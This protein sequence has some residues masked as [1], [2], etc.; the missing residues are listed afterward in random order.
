MAGFDD[1]EFV[2]T[3]FEMPEELTEPDRIAEGYGEGSFVGIS[4]RPDA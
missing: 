1:F 4:A 2:Q 3:V